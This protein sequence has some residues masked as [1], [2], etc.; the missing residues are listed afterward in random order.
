[1]SSLA[2]QVSCAVPGA[3]CKP[4]RAQRFTN[5]RRYV[6]KKQ[7][8][9]IGTVILGLL[10]ALA[11]G[12]ISITASPRDFDG[13]GYA[14]LV[15]GVPYENVSSTTD[16]GSVSVVYGTSAGLSGTGNEYWVQ[17][18]LDGSDSE[19]YEYFGRALAVGD[20][21][22]DG[23]FDLAVGVSHEDVGSVSQAGAV[24]VIYGS[25]S[26]GLDVAGN[27]YWNQDEP[28]MAGGAETNDHFGWA[29]AAGDFDGDGYDDL[30]IGIPDE[31]ISTTVDAGGMMVMYGSA[32]GLTAANTVRNQ[33]GAAETGDQ[34]GKA[35]AAGDFDNDGY[36]DLAVGIPSE[37]LGSIANAGAVDIYYGSASGLIT[38]VSNDFWPQDRSGVAD[39]ADE[40]DFFGSSLTVGDFDGDGYTD[41]A[42][43]VPH[44]DVGSP[45]VV[46]AGAV[47]VLYGSASGITGSGS[48]YWHQDASG[49]GSLNEDSDRFGFAL[50]AGDFDGDGYKDLAVGVP[51]EH[52]NEADTGIV[53]VLYGTADG[54]SGAGDQ[55]WRQD[56]SGIAD[57]EEADDRYGY[58]LA[59]GNFDGDG[60]DD[61]AIGVPYEAI[62]STD[63]AGAA[64]VLY[65]S[66]L[67]LTAAGSQFWYQGSGGLQGSAET[68]DRFGWALAALPR[69]RTTVY[70]PLILRN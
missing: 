20:F 11:V 58:A 30:A 61:L 60:Y 46:D 62:G 52:W 1:M 38:R 39:T 17:D 8:I 44:E 51:Y 6:V 4:A 29:L 45:A 63:Q 43:G 41:L 23:Y 10:L 9:C 32:S 5:Q 36:D 27:Q 70:L 57:V 12:P 64:N 55:L 18:Y 47:N 50:T 2:A 28:G 48:D 35:L 67:G 40:H 25:A 56:I 21:D 37:D 15:I 31:D 26:G 13:D 42:V 33:E 7:Q 68:G 59:A 19:T 24:N 22:G 34:Y 53:Q 65:G 69:V 14:D 16:A 49:I 3:G 54:L 66:D